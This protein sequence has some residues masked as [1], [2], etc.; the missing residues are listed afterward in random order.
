METLNLLV[1]AYP[2]FTGPL[3]EKMKVYLSEQEWDQSMDAATRY[4]YL[5][6]YLTWCPILFFHWTLSVTCS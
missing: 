6:L 3:V 1:V 2:D 4:V 5:K